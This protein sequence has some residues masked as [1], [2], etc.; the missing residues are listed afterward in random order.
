M[1]LG[2]TRRLTLGFQGGSF[3]YIN[4][5]LYIYMFSLFNHVHFT[6]S[7]CLPKSL[8][9]FCVYSFLFFYKLLSLSCIFFIQFFSFRM[10][11][12]PYCQEPVYLSL[13]LN[14]TGIFLYLSIYL[15]IFNS[16]QFSK[17]CHLPRHTNL[18]L[19][20]TTFY[21][22][23]VSYHHCSSLSPYSLT[24]SYLLFLQQYSTF[25]HLYIFI[26]STY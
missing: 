11:L 21:L 25:Q 7:K 14:T 24:L 12:F 6:L 17:Y 10:F 22:Y 13:Y 8:K 20:S 18:D 2:S 16:F 23:M 3:L 9:T 19:P 26:L 15:F 5:L 1:F 4:Y